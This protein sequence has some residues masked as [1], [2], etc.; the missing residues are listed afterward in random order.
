MSA[1]AIAFVGSLVYECRVL[2]GV[3]AEHLEDQDGELL[4]K[5]GLDF[6][7]RVQLVGHQITPCT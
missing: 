4:S 7:G 3:L 6:W 2:L 5:D 1:P